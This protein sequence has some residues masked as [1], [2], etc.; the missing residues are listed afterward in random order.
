MGHENMS[1]RIEN[2]G[3]GLDKRLGQIEVDIEIAKGD[4]DMIFQ[5]VNNTE[6]TMNEVAK[7]MLNNIL[8]V[9]K[10]TLQNGTKLENAIEKI[11]SEA[12]KNDTMDI[13]NEQNLENLSNIME[14]LT[15]LA[16]DV[17]GM[18]NGINNI[19]NY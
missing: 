12:Q 17:S 10:E 7:P 3:T 4:H 19:L 9:Q 14:S 6:S 2:I 16:Q 18:Q 5:V 13:S 1:K 11:T 15:R 8:N